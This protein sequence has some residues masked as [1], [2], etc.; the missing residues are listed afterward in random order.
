MYPVIVP[1]TP[2]SEH[3]HVLHMLHP[4]PSRLKAEVDRKVATPAMRLLDELI[5]ILDPVGE[6]ESGEYASP[7]GPAGNDEGAGANGLA[8]LYGNGAG[9]GAAAAAAAG[10]AGAPAREE[11]ERRQRA[12][13]RMQAAFGLGLPSDADVMSLAAQL[14]QGGWPACWEER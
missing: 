7:A 6:E 4:R 14:A 2:S 8:G 1:C 3:A 5:N 13:A 11:A 12:A 10:P 9:H